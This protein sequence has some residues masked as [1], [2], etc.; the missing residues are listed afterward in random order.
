MTA[1]PALTCYVRTGYV[2]LVN[3]ET[4]QTINSNITDYMTH[5]ESCHKYP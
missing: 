2:V 5:N 1:G 3:V 4:T